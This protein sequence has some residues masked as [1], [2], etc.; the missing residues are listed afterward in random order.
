MITYQ[1][2]VIHC[3]LIE[4]TMKEDTKYYTYRGDQIFGC[5]IDA[6]KAFEQ[7]RYGKSLSIFV[8]L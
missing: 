8:D 3:V 7:G 2:E 4:L 6:T 1:N 5:L